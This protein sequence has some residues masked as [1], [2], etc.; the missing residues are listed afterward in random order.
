MERLRWLL[1]RL[2]GLVRRRH[3]TD[4]LDEEVRFHLEEE[5]ER[6]DRDRRLAGGGHG[7][8]AS[9]AW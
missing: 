8:C 5:A 4:A 3:Y 2:R 1:F 9:I 7:R 6:L